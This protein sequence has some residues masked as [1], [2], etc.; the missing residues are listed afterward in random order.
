M[1]LKCGME[2]EMGGRA[3]E[4]VVLAGLSFP[5]CFGPGPSGNGDGVG[6]RSFGAEGAVPSLCDNEVTMFPVLCQSQFSPVSTGALWG[7]LIPFSVG[8]LLSFRC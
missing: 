4:P 6:M 1:S 2:K 8:F 7:H 3:A 5:H